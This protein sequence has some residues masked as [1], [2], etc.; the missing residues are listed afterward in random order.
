M[1]IGIVLVGGEYIST[2]LGVDMN[3]VT[4]SIDN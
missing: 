4:L 1:L 2:A 3:K